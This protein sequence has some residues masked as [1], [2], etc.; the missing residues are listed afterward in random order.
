MTNFI[1]TVDSLYLRDAPKK[2]GSEIIGVLHKNDIVT[3]VG[4]NS[5]NWENVKTADGKT[6]WASNAY[7]Q[8]TDETTKQYFPWFEKAI[9]EYNKHIKEIAGS[10]DNSRIVEYLRSTD[11]GSVSA[12]NDETP[13][14]SAFVNWCVEQSDKQGTN[15]AWARS[16]L[17]WGKETEMPI[18][19]CIAVFKRPPNPSSGH[20]AFFVSQTNTHVKVLGGN[21]SD[22]VSITAYPADRLLSYRIP[23]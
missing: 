16:W 4:P 20:V 5:G 21:Q 19:G 11:L 9:E 13:W 17:T 22:S 23:N 1:V 3:S 14:C 10:G 6:G 8:V 12:K 2:D 15:S 18:K 7:L